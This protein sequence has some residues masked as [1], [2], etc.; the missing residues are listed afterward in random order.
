MGKDLFSIGYWKH[1]TA[2]YKRMDHY[3]TPYTKIIS[4]W[5]KDS[6]VRLEIIKFLEGS[7]EGKLLDIGLD[8]EF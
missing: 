1:W 7:I 8:N 3:L 4:K 2:I 5:V 6:N